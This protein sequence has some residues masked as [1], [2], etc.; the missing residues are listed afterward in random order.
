[1]SARFA[2]RTEMDGRL[3]AAARHG[4]DPL[5]RERDYPAVIEPLLNADGRLGGAGMRQIGTI[6]AA[7][8]ELFISI[9]ASSPRAATQLLAFGHPTTVGV[10]IVVFFMRI[11]RC[12]GTA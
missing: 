8:A 12:G 11:M 7:A 6:A 9:I 10:A 5:L 3:I 1:V 4:L 2:T